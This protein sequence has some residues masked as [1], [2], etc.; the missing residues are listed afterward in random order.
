MLL[1]GAKADLAVV[2]PSKSM[3]SDRGDQ[4]GVA[5][6][7]VH[8]AAVDCLLTPGCQLDSFFFLP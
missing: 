4:F 2:S 6:P 7:L 5:V 8:Q 1:V 3:C